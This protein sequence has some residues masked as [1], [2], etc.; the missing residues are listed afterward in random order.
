MKI[1]PV[2]EVKARFS[3]YLR[4]CREGPVIVTKNGR[5]TA[6]LLSVSNEEELERLVLAHTPRFMALLD[7]AGKRIKRTGGVRHKEFW[8][9]IKKKGR[10]EKIGA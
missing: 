6:V 4:Q 1:A 9:A 7:R 3:S 2:A 8:A 5:P 10:R